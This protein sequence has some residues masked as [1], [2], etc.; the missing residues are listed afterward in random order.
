MNERSFA[1]D[2]DAPKPSETSGVYARRDGETT[3]VQRAPVNTW[4]RFTAPSSDAAENTRAIRQKDVAEAVRRA[5]SDLLG[6][7]IRNAY[8]QRA[9]FNDRP[10]DT[11]L[12]ET[13][14]NWDP[15][16]GLPEGV[17]NW[18][19]RRPLS[20]YGRVDIRRGLAGQNPY[21]EGQVPYSASMEKALQ[22]FSAS[23]QEE[24]LAEIEQK[25]QEI[26]ERWMQRD[27]ELRAMRNARAEG[28]ERKRLSEGG[29]L[30]YNDSM[31][32]SLREFEQGE[33]RDRIDSIASRVKAER[34]RRPKEMLENPYAHLAGYFEDLP[35]P[36]QD[37]SGELE[38]DIEA[39]EARAALR[40]AVTSPGRRSPVPP[41]RPS[42]VPP[43][44]PRYRNVG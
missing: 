25:M 42:H 28:L 15:Y 36:I 21:T 8:Q 9:E 22:E 12:L 13:E 7:D 17:R 2:K 14:T 33:L 16:A 20:E 6:S 40:A 39:D 29:E 5:G 11:D 4:E 26:R 41:S 18:Q 37:L 3:R 10:V 1:P 23:E 34:A 38:D 19:P 24:I 44:L 31:E 35:E 32:Q 30:A 43:P 27:Y